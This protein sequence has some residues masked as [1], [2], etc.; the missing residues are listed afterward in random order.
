MERIDEL[1][2]QS[3]RIIQET[4][5]FCF[6][7]DAVLLAHMVEAR[8]CDR[9]LD[10]GTGNGILPLLLY[11][12][13]KG[14]HF[15]GVEVQP[16]VA[17]LARRSVDLNGLKDSITIHTGSIADYKAPP[18]DVIVTNPPYL[19]A[20]TGARAKR[21]AQAIA[22]TES[23]LTL[24]VLFQ[25]ARKLL[26]ERGSLYMIHRPDRLVDII[27]EA[28]IH[29]IE[30]K[31]LRLVKSYQTSAPSMVLLHFVKGAGAQLTILED[32]VIYDALGRYT[33][34]V[35]SYYEGGL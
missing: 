22:R 32:L 14:V 34:E 20:G 26:K 25:A 12:Y 21:S 16:Q 35:S 17:D 29:R 7:I 30:P 1:Q 31:L 10:I 23:S 33:K 15:D 24:S 8:S 9:V 13:G 19:R 27:A 2:C 11:G 5:Q 28:R 6:G 3:L 4:E 18:Y